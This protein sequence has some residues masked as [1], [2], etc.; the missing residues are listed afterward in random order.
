MD[1]FEFAGRHETDSGLV[2]ISGYIDVMHEKR[3]QEYAT[4]LKGIMEWH[5]Q[6]MLKDTFHGDLV[7]MLLSAP[8]T[9]E[10]WLDQYKGF[11]RFENPKASKDGLSFT[12]I[13]TDMKKVKSLPLFGM[14]FSIGRPEGSVD[15]ALLVKRPADYS[16]NKWLTA[17]LE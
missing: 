8:P 2:V 12:G 5:G 9:I 15:A 6:R 16:A 14:E 11:Y 1:R 3:T 4:P 10:M 7:Q 17:L 13:Y